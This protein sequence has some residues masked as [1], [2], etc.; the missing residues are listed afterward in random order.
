MGEALRV[1]WSRE[2][3][4]PYTAVT[5]CVRDN[6]RGQTHPHTLVSKPLVLQGLGIA[7]TSVVPAGQFASSRKLAAQMVVLSR[8]AQQVFYGMCHL[9]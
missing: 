3:V 1:P 4:P 2:L 6:R 8:T 5:L 7:T 9:P